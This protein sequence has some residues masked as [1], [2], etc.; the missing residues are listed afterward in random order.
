MKEDFWHTVCPI[1][2]DKWQERTCKSS[3]EVQKDFYATFFDKAGC[4]VVKNVFEPELMQKYN[5]WC[6]NFLET[7]KDD[8]NCRHPKVFKNCLQD[9]PRWNHFNTIPSKK[10][11]L[12]STNCFIEWVSRSQ[13]FC[14]NL[15]L[16]KILI[17]VR[18]PFLVFANMVHALL[19]GLNLVE[20]VKLGIHFSNRLKKYCLYEYS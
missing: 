4:V 13:T 20:I 7:A 19:T 18:T 15:L 2:F 10:T 16:I 11:N 17:C 12:W 6:E 1:I 14:S 8:P 5:T 9:Y 3:K